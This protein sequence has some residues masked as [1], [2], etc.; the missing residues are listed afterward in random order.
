MVAAG[1]SSGK[2]CWLGRHVP[3]TGTVLTHVYHVLGTYPLGIRSSVVPCTQAVW[4]VESSS[5]GSDQSCHAGQGA[6]R[7][8]RWRIGAA[9]SQQDGTKEA[10]VLV[11]KSEVDSIWSR[12][13]GCRWLARVGTDPSLVLSFPI[14]PIGSVEAASASALSTE[15]EAVTAEAANTLSTHVSQRS[16]T[17]FNEQWNEVASHA[18]ACIE[19]ERSAIESALDSLGLRPEVVDCVSWDLLHW[20]LESYF[21][22]KIGSSVLFFDCLFCVYRSGHL[23]CGWRGAW[24]NGVLQVL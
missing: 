5:D 12:I 6:C 22:E 2:R 3:R 17:A 7:S 20:V 4:P 24:P 1:G 13:A 15:W 11:A 16:R 9:R 10:V 18:Q 19:S 14:D 8:I 21:H 23:P